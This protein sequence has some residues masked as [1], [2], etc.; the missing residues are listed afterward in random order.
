MRRS[1]LRK[2][3]FV[4]VA[5]HRERVRHLHLSGHRIC[6][7]VLVSDARFWLGART[8]PLRRCARCIRLLRHA[9]DEKGRTA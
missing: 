9:L 1:I 5:T 6:L 8:Q 4:W 3:A 7:F 2:E